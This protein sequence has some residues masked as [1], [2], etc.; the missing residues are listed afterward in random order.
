MNWSSHFSMRMYWHLYNEV[1]E[2]IVGLGGA[3]GCAVAVDLL[4]D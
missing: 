3:S 1:D 2:Q 4:L